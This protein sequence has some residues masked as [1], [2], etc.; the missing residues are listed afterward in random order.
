LQA[1][2]TPVAYD[3]DVLFLCAPGPLDNTIICAATV[4]Q[5]ILNSNC[6]DAMLAWSV[7]AK[8][9]ATDNEADVGN[10]SLHDE[11]RIR[12]VAH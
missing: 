1:E 4:L 2:A 11:Y 6:T 8:A 9:H 7:Q 10:E 3:E 5:R 12:R